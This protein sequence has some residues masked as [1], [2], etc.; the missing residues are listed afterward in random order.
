VLCA[1]TSRSR[2]ASVS[3]EAEASRFEQ[4]GLVL[5]RSTYRVS[6]RNAPPST[7]STCRD[8]V[9]LTAQAASVITAIGAFTPS[10]PQEK[11][12]LKRRYGTLSS[13][14]FQSLDL[15]VWGIVRP[16]DIHAFHCTPRKASTSHP[17]ANERKRGGTH[18]GGTDF[19]AP[20]ICMDGM[21]GLACGH[22]AHHPV[23]RVGTELRERV[24]VFTTL[25]V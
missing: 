16:G 17:I 18:R 22:D 20:S 3:V 10:T 4:P 5:H 21:P 1:R 7:W 6:S 15:R 13:V 14:T 9:D 25:Y 24:C 19:A 8:G 23:P 12:E 11:A 2:S